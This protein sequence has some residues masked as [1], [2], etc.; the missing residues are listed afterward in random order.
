MDT[1]PSDDE[2]DTLEVLRLLAAANGDAEAVAWLMATVVPAIYAFV[3]PRVPN[4]DVAADIVQDVLLEGLRSVHNFRG[5]APAAS[6]F[7]TIARR[8]VARHWERE[9]RS[10]ETAARLN[11]VP[12]HQAAVHEW[13]A[14]RDALIET[15]RRLAPLHRQALVLRYIDDLAVHDVAAALGRSEVQT[16][17]LLQ[18]ARAQLRAELEES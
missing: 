11:A 17:S 10:A 3:Y 8:S 9:R 4:D 2:D 18:R 13:H 15:L 6:W 16:Q 1:A 14:D 7:R 5:R 12:K